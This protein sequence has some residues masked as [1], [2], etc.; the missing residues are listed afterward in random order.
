MKEKRTLHFYFDFIS[1]FAYFAWQELPTFCEKHQLHFEAHPIVFGAVLDHCGQLGPAEIDSKRDWTYKQCYRLAKQKSVSFKFPPQHPFNPIQALRLSLIEASGKNQA[2]IITAIFNAVWAQGKDINSPETL[3]QTFADLEL[4]EQYLISKTQTT[5]VKQAL[6][7]ETEQAIQF[8]V[9]GVPTFRID[10]ELFW[11][12]DQLP[13]I[14][15]F[16]NGADAVDL[17]TQKHLSSITVGVERKQSK[18]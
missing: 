3:S 6:F 11:G 5:E 17:E 9:F 15:D 2:S 18:S 7:S 4:D 1:P 16:L 13:Y 10:S 8:G 12:S 14:E